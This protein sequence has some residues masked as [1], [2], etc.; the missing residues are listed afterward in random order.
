MKKKA[1]ERLK[2]FADQ[3]P[4]GV[5]FFEPFVL[6][7]W[8]CGDR[9]VV[10]LLL[11]RLASSAAK[12]ASPVLQSCL[13]ASAIVGHESAYSRFEAERTYRSLPYGV[14]ESGPLDQALWHHLAAGVVP[15]GLVSS[16]MRMFIE[17]ANRGLVHGS[18]LRNE[19]SGSLGDST[20]CSLGG[21]QI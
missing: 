17:K 3:N 2:L 6:D 15:K 11:D 18:S 19:L 1:V 8:F 16:E 12:L 4:D 9:V 5:A 10:P 13:L 21:G 7:F 20:E 14:A